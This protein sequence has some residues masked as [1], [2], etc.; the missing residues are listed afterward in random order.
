[1]QEVLLV[2]IMTS[3][4]CGILGPFIVLRNLSMTADALSHSVLL[5]IVVAFLFV[6]DL[7]SIWL[8]VGAAFFGL[9]TVFAV[10][11][12]SKKN[13][14]K[15]DD[16]LG[17]VFPM[18]FA[19]AVIIITKMFRNAHLDVD[20]VLMGNPLFAPFVRMFD[21]PKSFVN[22]LIIFII[23][24][25]FVVVAYKPLKMSTFDEEYSTL[26]GI[27]MNT[28]FYVLMT[29]TSL[30]CVTAFD[31]VGAILV[32]SL[33]VAPSASAYLITKDLKWTIVYTLIFGIINVSI[34]YYF[35]TLWNVSVSGMCSIVGMLTCLIT[36][37]FNPK[38]V[39]YKRIKKYKNINKLG[40]DLVLI[41]IYRHYH[42]TDEL[43]FDSIHQHLNWN[44]AKTEKHLKYLLDEA[45][46]VKNNQ[47]NLYE[48]S[49]KGLNHVKILLGK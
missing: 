3:M 22:M 36:V 43:G 41:H 39:I 9:L 15:K 28:L 6:K 14:V 7:D 34:G 16:A 23:N 12:L 37:I 21:L 17:I 49:E 40:N 10:E 47:L 32:I 35:G 46:I 11:I 45:L 33:F 2:L 30:T 1:M 26:Q 18:F 29:L 20:I 8:T 44:G 31:S 38:G 24:L 13:L 19:L 42:N 4:A 27:K 48:L 25:I 5:G